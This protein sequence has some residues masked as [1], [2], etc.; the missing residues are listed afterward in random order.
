MAI[1]PAHRAS[2]SV[3]ANLKFPERG[4]AR[5]VSRSGAVVL[6]LVCDT[7]AL[8]QIMTLAAP[9]QRLS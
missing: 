9:R 2:G 5:S 3:L 1:C 7:A 8:R 4:C 6:R